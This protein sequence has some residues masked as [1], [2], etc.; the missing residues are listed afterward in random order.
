MDNSSHFLSKDIFEKRTTAALSWLKRSID[1]CDGKGSAAYYSRLYKPLRGWSGAYPETTGYIIE[2]FFDYSETYKDQTLREYAIKSTDWIC[3]LQL[4]SGAL[5][6]GLVSSNP[7]PSIFN[8]GQMIFGLVR[9]YEETNDDKYKVVFTKACNW[10]IDV[11]EEDGS[12][13]QGAY[14]EGY[15]PSYYTRVIWS[16]LMA[17]VHIKDQNIEDK[18]VHA[19][20]YYKAKINENFTV[21]DW[22]FQEGQ[23]AFTHTI[24]Y[25]IRGFLESAL[26]L[27]NEELIETSKKFGEKIMRLRE[28]KGAMAGWYD[29]NWK[30]SYKF[31]CLTGNCQLSIILSKLY[32]ITSDIR[33]Y[34][35]SL[36]IFGDVV[37]KQKLSSNKNKNGAIA[38]SSPV[39]GRYLFMRYPNWAAKFYLEAYL[40]LKQ[41]YDSLKSNS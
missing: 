33:Y 18:M 12:W 30:G 1:V 14:K 28:L 32:R 27:Q 38:G 25:T 5:P 40:L 6:G 2:T 11:L 4:D 13:K 17:N 20:N 39:W 29:Q 21:T 31:T 24:A 37:N 8:T 26:L 15:V 35:T 9:A 10:L 34:N 41:E 19:L 36:K 23:K 3:G 22:S 16:V 7:S